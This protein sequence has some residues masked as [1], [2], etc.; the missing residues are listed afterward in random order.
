MRARFPYSDYS[1]NKTVGGLG[2]VLFFLPLL[3]CPD[4]RYGRFCANQGLIGLIAILLIMVSG[5]VLDLVIGW[6]PLIGSLVGLIVSLA[7][8]A[9]GIVM[10][11]YAF[12]AIFKDD[13][14]ELPFIGHYNILR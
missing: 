7:R 3:L 11:Y 5:W 9:V 6:L 14:R 2:Y 4:S 12:L 10:I 1:K 8:A 13:E